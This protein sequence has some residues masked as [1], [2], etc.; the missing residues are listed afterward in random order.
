VARPPESALLIF[1]G[2]CAFCRRWIA[3]WKRT[4]GD[5]VDYAPFQSADIAA[6]F[7]EIPRAQL[8]SAVHLIE[9][10]G[11]VTRAA[12]AV[13]RSLA[14]SHPWPLRLYK[15]LPGFSAITEL[16]YRIVAANRSLAS[17]VTDRL[18][19]RRVE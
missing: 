11:R 2:D 6:K 13:F 14:V 8:E 1:D 16:L 15:N 7:P 9:P 12:E 17:W 18:W 10:D 4:T 19:G 5:A 3:R